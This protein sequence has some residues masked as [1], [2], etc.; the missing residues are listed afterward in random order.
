MLRSGLLLVLFTGL[1]SAKVD[2]TTQVAP[3]LRSRC[4]GCHGAAQQMSGLRLDTRDAA[5]A[6]GRLFEATVVARVPAGV[7]VAD[8]ARRIERLADDLQVDVAFED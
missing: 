2:F 1:L 6:G 4:Q 8:L 7:D 3:L 5:M